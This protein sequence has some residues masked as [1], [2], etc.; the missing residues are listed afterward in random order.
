MLL[1][2]LVASSYIV[3]HEENRNKYINLVVPTKYMQLKQMLCGIQF[4]V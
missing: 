1:K 2:Y 3:R 4:R